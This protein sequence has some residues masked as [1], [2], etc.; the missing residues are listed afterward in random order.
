MRPLNRKSNTQALCP[1]CLKWMGSVATHRVAEDEAAA[2][3]AAQPVGGRRQVFDPPRPL[4][5]S[6]IDFHASRPLGG[7]RLRGQLPAGGGQRRGRA[8]QH[9][10]RDYG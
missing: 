1:I 5:L 9:G 4:H 2:V 10:G 6:A 3:A 7:Q 8:W